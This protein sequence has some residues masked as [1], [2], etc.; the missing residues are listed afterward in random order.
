MEA[1]LD[2][3]GYSDLEIDR[4]STAESGA[5]APRPAYS[6]MSCEKAAARGVR[7]RSWREA[8][9]AFFDSPDLAIARELSD[10]QAKSA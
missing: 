10:P 1:V 4:I 7:L 8:L 6:V 3:G 5:A 2:A 9:A